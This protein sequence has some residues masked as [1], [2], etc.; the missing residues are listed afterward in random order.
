MGDLVNYRARNQ[1]ASY[2][3][4][5]LTTRETAREVPSMPLH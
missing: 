5:G 2:L 4:S 3:D 1:K